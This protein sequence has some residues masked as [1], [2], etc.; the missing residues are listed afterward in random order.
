MNCLETVISST[1][2]AS[3][4]GDFLQSRPAADKG[5]FSKH[6]LARF[7]VAAIRKS[8][9]SREIQHC[10]SGTEDLPRKTV[11]PVVTKLFMVQRALKFVHLFFSGYVISKLEDERRCRSSARKICMTMRW[12]ELHDEHEIICYNVKHSFNISVGGFQCIVCCFCR[13]DP[14]VPSS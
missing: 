4:M 10:T 12:A 14:T 7:A 3:I 11:S 8:L 9:D 13:T 6:V 2:A 5:Q 1:H